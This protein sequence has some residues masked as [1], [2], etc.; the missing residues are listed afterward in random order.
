MKGRPKN[1]RKISFMPAVSGFRPYGDSVTGGDP[2][3][4]FYEEYEAVRL[5]D[6]EKHTQCAAAEIMGVSRP[7]FT[8][9]YMHAREKI[10]QAFVEGRQIVVE[11]G[12]VELDGSW[13][14]CGQCHA[15]FSQVGER[16][17][18]C[19][20]CGS[21]DIHAYRLV[22]DAGRTAAKPCDRRRAVKAPSAGNT[23]NEKNI[24]Q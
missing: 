8:R 14:E 16:S 9:I 19:A 24:E 11:G 7:T 3:F 20:L 10:A 12:K 17:D 13:F 4:L 21:R 18:R 5:N 2:V 1:V 6:Y 22:P 15:V 23:N